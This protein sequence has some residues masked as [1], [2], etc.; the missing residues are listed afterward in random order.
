MNTV[1]AVSY[2]LL[3]VRKFQA[4]VSLEEATGV[5]N[6]IHH[7]NECFHP[8]NKSFHPANER[9]DRPESPAP[10]FGVPEGG[11]AFSVRGLYNQIPC[12]IG[13]FPQALADAIGPVYLG[14][15]NPNNGKFTNLE[16]SLGNESGGLVA[17]VRSEVSRRKGDSPERQKQALE[18]I[19]KRF[20]D[21]VDVETHIR[22]DGS[23]P[24]IV[25]RFNF[26]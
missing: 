17:Y 1:D 7:F 13:E 24:V 25:A 5:L 14:E 15:G 8:A 6:K 2:M 21:R 10:A 22:R 3:H 9:S 20:A 19:G 18:K 26:E 16:F 23:Y 12:T 11:P 4:T